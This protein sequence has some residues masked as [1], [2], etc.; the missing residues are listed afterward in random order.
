MTEPALNKP[1]HTFEY[2]HSCY[3]EDKRNESSN[4]AVFV[5]RN[6]VTFAEDGSE[7]LTPE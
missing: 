2:I 1:K 3:T 6:R 5:K 7:I 4:D